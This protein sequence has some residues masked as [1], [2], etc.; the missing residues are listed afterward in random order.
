MDASLAFLNDIK[1]TSP[2][3]EHVN[4]EIITDDQAVNAI[5]LLL[6]WVGEDVSREGLQETPQRVTRAWKEFFSGYQE[7]PQKHLE[8]TF[9]EVAGYDEAITLKNI[10]VESYCEHH[11]VPIIG[12]AFISYIPKNRVAG[13]SKLA[14]VME[15]Y[16]RRMQIQERLTAQVAHAINDALDPIGVAVAIRAEHQC[17]STRGVHKPGTKMLT[18]STIGE[19]KTNESR[20][21]EFMSMVNYKTS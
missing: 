18:V 11:L 2:I 16:A 9:E 8:V 6:E 13:I 12:E 20:R 1:K 5:R 4:K 14:R 7:D 17:I 10:R 21:Q 19:F 3:T 15:G